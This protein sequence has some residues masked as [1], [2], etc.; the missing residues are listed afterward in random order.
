VALLKWGDKTMND[1]IIQSIQ[2]GKQV[3][4]PKKVK[5]QLKIELAFYEKVITD[6]E[7]VSDKTKLVFLK[8]EDAD[9]FERKTWRN[10]LL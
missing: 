5:S 6:I 7:K 1:L 10:F 8:W 4:M 3:V 9:E 2:D